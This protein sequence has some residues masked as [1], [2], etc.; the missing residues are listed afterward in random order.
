MS[1]VQQPITTHFKFQYQIHPLLAEGVDVVE[2]ES[3]DDVN[4]VAFMSGDAVLRE[5][6]N[7]K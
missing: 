6:F 3:D 1:F 5:K 4:A 7:E 2:D